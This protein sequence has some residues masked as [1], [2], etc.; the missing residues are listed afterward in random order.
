[1][2]S[3]FVETIDA[4]DDVWCLDVGCAWPDDR[5]HCDPV[6]VIGDNYAISTEL[7]LPCGGVYV[8]PVIYM[9]SEIGAAL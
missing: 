8:D 6:Q 3:L 5:Y 9:P 1:M 4:P 2:D 7:A